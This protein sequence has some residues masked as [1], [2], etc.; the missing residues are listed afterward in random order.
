[1]LADVFNLYTVRCIAGNIY[2]ALIQIVEADGAT[3]FGQ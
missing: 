1:L 3:L 2:S